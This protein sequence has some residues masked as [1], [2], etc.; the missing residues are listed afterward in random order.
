MLSIRIHETGGA[1]K[2][3]ADNVPVP[4]PGEGEIRLRVEA[5][6]VNYVDTYHRSGLYPV[7][8]PH[9]LGGEAAGT[10]S[11]IGNGV[12]GFKVGD[13]VVTARASGGYS[14]ETIAPVSQVVRVPA[15]ISSP[16]AAALLVQ[17]L[18]ASFLAC[19]TFPLRPGNTAL[20]HAAA[21]GVGLLLTQIARLRGARVLGTV[22]SDD[23]VALARE[24]G[25]EQVCVYTRESF[26]DAARA[27]TGGRGVDVAYDGVGRQTFEGTLDSLRPRGMFVSYGNASGPVPPFAPLLLTKKGSLFFTR[28]TMAHYIETPAELQTRSDELFA[29]V[30]AGKVKVRIGA[31]FPLSAAAD[32]H[33]A[34]ESRGTTGKIL[35]IP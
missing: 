29:W 8:L 32:A 33:R 28:P 34:I 6:G 31:T 7:T 12:T 35:L 19:D 10:V 18:T 20:V 26:V 4:V 5:A 3:R 23:K 17:G 15:G 9:A 2:L 25:A 21:G 22:G 1:E 13:R 27:F 30:S 24:A 14:E 11:A 16:V